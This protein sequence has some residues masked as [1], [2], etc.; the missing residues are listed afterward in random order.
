MRHGLVLG[1]FYPPHK[2]HH[3]LVREA[4]RAC[5]RVT[6][7]VLGASVESMSID[8][9]V[10][11]MQVEHRSDTNVTIIGA[12]DDVPID[13]HDD[14]T[15]KQHVDLFAAV[16][17]RSV[18]MQGLSPTAAVVDAVF[19]AEPY[20]DELARRLNAVHV[21]V[22]R[23][24]A[25]AA[26]NVRADV[27]GHWDDLAS[28]TKAG[29]ALRVVFTGA[30][31]TGTTTTSR[32]VADEFRRREGVWSSTQ[33]VPE[34]G[35]D[36][37]IGRLAAATA[38]TGVEPSMHDLLWLQED[39]VD[40]ARRQQDME[41]AAAAAGGPVLVCDTDAFTTG[42]WQER[43]MQARSPKVDA[44][45][46]EVDHCLYLVTSHVGVPFVQDGIRDG[47]KIREWM[48]ERIIERLQETGRN[49][50]LLEGLVTERAAMAIRQIDDQCL[51]S[52]RFASPLTE[53]VA[54]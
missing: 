32:M 44:V 15:W 31:S 19:T 35:R 1:K 12:L 22:D 7:L 25:M 49:W 2:G 3:W 5:E 24:D 6:V 52:F 8:D 30:E 42:I 18:V 26:T 28:A 10:R 33:W 16:I 47:E 13:Y 48:T 45:S 39:F 9:R 50:R 43:Y 4:A 54:Q 20:G 37:T 38:L 27:I 40:I 34:F 23:K 17:A 11:W 21:R 51:R 46:E 53:G 36:Y 41:D 14:L 29:L